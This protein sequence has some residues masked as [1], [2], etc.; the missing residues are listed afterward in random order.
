MARKRKGDPVHGWLVLD[1][2]EGLSS[3]QALGVVR[4]LFN[5]QK[6]GHGGTLD[7]L[8][9]GILPVAFGE[10]TKTVSWAMDGEKTYRFALTC[11]E[12]R[13]TDDRE[14]EVTERSDVLPDDE[15]L[16]ALLPRFTGEITQI[17]PVYSAIHVN[18]KRSYALAR[19]DEAVE[20]PPRQVVI[21]RLEMLE[22]LSEST[23]LF[24]CACGK[25]TYIRSL[26]R[27][28][29]LA[30]GSVGHVS[31]LRRTRVGSFSTE[32]AISLEE[33][34]EMGHSPELLDRL[35]PIRAAL[36]DIPAISLSE[37]EA[38]SLKSG[39]PVS[40][41]RQSD[42]S[43]ARP[44]IEAVRQGQDIFPAMCGETLVALVRME[45]GLL[46]PVRVLH[47]QGNPA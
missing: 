43:R 4:R 9:S 18:G 22:R 12:A 14:G 46:K 2:P 23:V 8:A 29:A 21:H 42:S 40:L 34:R 41:M 39:Q 15:T 11:G 19:A 26:A 30:A 6:A 1:K 32:D 28:L 5:A 33:L 16:R 24:E 7:P 36:D 35:L 13:S 47:V 17:P 31:L 20:L 38:S 10:A 25:G 45:A 3:T 27:D 37:A 44:L